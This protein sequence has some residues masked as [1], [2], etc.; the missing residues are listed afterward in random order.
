MMK[1][2]KWQ[3]IIS[4]VLIL[5]PGVLGLLLWDQ[6]PPL[7]ATHWGIDG[8]VDG[9]GSPGFVVFGLPAIMLALHWFC[10]WIHYKDPRNKEQGSKAAW[11][12]FWLIPV[13]SFFANGV[14]YM[15]AAGMEF[16]YSFFLAA[17]L[18]GVF[19][20]I[21]NYMPKFRQNFTMGIKIKW[22]FSSEANWNATHRLAGKLWFLGGLL[23]LF[24]AF[25]PA[26]VALITILVLII[27][28]VAIPTV[29]S[30][31][32]YQRELAEG[33]V[34][35]GQKPAQTYP[36]ALKWVTA[37]FLPLL[38][39]FV[40]VVMFTGDVQLQ[41]NETSFLVDADFWSELTVEYEAMDS[42]EY[43]EQFDRGARVS[44]VGSARLLAGV[45]QNKEFGEYTLYSY[46]GCESAVI[47]HVD[48]KVLAI[49]GEDAAATQQIYQQL[50]EKVQEG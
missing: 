5:L 14:I 13:I 32:Y 39:V 18:G 31:R 6:L 40:C 38:L 46:T 37:V 41:Y 19:M 48:G 23:M 50:L 1:K 21:G 9:M 33:K 35:P 11:F 47:V 16:N 4:S 20:I 30:Y 25:L 36:K 2:Y 15:A 26:T 28:M 10:L 44:G 42:V 12:I 3:L 43:R 17:I 22:T 24:T 45:F 29:Y 7:M 27:P 49:S 8:K 34:L